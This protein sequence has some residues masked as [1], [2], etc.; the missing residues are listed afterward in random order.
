MTNSNIFGD[1]ESLLAT[2]DNCNERNAE[3]AIALNVY[4]E[5]YRQVF[6]CFGR[7]ATNLPSAVVTVFINGI[8][9]P[10]VCGLAEELGF[11]IR[12]GN[13]FG[14]NSSW[15]LWWLK[16]LEFFQDARAA[17][18]FKF[19]PDTMVDAN[20]QAIPENDYFGTVM[21]SNPWGTPFVQG[22]ITGLSQN[23]VCRLLK[24]RLLEPG[25]NKPW[26]ALVPNSC[27]FMDDQLIAEALASLNIR[28]S[29]WQECMSVW[30]TP[31][32]NDPVRYA[33]V[34]PRYY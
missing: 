5:P 19:D 18:Y 11:Q 10:D 4:K 17:T 6:E 25:K 9:R 7:I 27:A 33:I 28:A 1:L 8:P 34:H 26:M 16:M 23:A 29:V 12:M 32:L 2:L 15:H 20:P 30:K 24:E 3:I 14:A 13:N 31:V 22:G 21:H